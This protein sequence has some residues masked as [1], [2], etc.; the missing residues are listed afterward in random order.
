MINYKYGSQTDFTCLV[1]GVTGEVTGDRQYSFTKVTLT[2]LVAFYPAALTT[3]VALGSLIDP[4]IGIALASFLTF[5]TSIPLA[6]ILSPLIGLSAK[7]Y[8]KIYRDRISQQQWNNYRSDSQQFTYDFTSSFRQQYQSYRQQQQQSYKQ[9]E[10]R[11][12]EPR[13]VYFLLKHQKNFDE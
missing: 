5:T 6:L 13:F 12:Q 9:Q 2:T 8:P 3:I 10:E 1:D 4:S 7:N 11:K